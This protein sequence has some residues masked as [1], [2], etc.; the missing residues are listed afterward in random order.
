MQALVKA[1]SAE[2]GLYYG[3]NGFFPPIPITL[4]S[5]WKY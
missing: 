3:K 1:Y 4:C 5:T 2:R